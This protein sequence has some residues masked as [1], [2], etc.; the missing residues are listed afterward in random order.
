MARPT[1]YDPSKNQ[2]VIDLMSEGASIVEVAGLLDVRR[3]TIYDWINSEH[4]SYQK[5][6]SETYTRVAKDAQKEVIIQNGL[7]SLFNPIFT[8]FVAVNMTEMRDKQDVAV[9]AQIA[10]KLDDKDRKALSKVGTKLIDAIL[11]NHRQKLL[12]DKTI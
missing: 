4:P 9:N 2:A 6:F 11:G 10:A 12:T 5:E 3:E 8:K 7:Q 1:K